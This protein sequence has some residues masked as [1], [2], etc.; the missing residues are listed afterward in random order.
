MLEDIKVIIDKFGGMYSRGMNDT[1]PL[2]HMYPC[3]NATF[4]RNEIRGRDGVTRSYNFN[5]RPRKIFSGVINTDYFFLSLD[6][7]NQLHRDDGA[8]ILDGSP[9]M[10]DFSALNLFNRVYI[11]P[12]RG[13]WADEIYQFLYVYTGTGSARLAGGVKPSSGV[14]AADGAA[15]V[16]S[17][18]THQLAVC[19]VTDTGFIT[20]PNAT[21]T[22][23]V[24]PGLKKIS[25]TNIPLGP[26]ECVGRR[27]LST[28]AGEEEL[29]FVPG[30]GIINDN[31]A[32]TA[33]LDY[34]DTDLVSSA[35]YLL[36]IYE[37]IPAGTQLV[38]YKGR[39][40][41]VGASYLVRISNVQD[42]ETFSTV[43]GF[44]AIPSEDYVQNHPVAGW[45]LRDT[46][47]ISKF[48]GV[49]GVQD[50]GSLFPNEWPVTSIDESIGCYP[51]GIGSYTAQYG[52]RSTADHNIILTQQGIALFN[53]VFLR[54]MM[55]WKV[56]DFWNSVVQGQIN[57]PLGVNLDFHKFTVA[58]DVVLKK[59]YINC[60]T[61]P[62]DQQGIGQD[63]FVLH[64]DYS[65]GWDPINVKWSL[66]TF[67]F[68]PA[69]AVMALHPIDNKYTL[70][71]AS[72][73]DNK[74]W[75]LD[76]DE[77]TDD[78][79][80]ITSILETGLVDR[81]VGVLTFFMGVQL[82]A[83]GA[84]SLAVVLTDDITTFT[85][86]NVVINSTYSRDYLRLTN[87]T[88]E[89]AKLRLT[90]GSVFSINRIEVKCRPMFLQRPQL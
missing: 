57:H 61:A 50:D 64:G 68:R 41:V 76:A 73:L 60:A 38:F 29:F 52:G 51:N 15:G 70:R 42:P 59:I 13:T 3:Q 75:S 6:D 28:K 84:T 72:Y 48:P 19:F 12:N 24:A 30:G 90:G 33:T 62:T 25:L 71:I 26:A 35:D 82:R 27:I 47:Y 1:V 10:S 43:D 45:V 5:F 80:N 32:T 37:R 40:C 89:K 58:H 20:P 36:D 65:E 8:S 77:T 86:V 14:T 69:A 31:T 22:A 2:D 56:E 46:L 4:N 17:K 44:L 39:L 63:W 49:F 87:Y 78:G 79:T 23:Y 7:I 83:K 21:L 11:S 81:E 74:L 9:D 16:V 88:S 53:G 54:P 55:S 34:A 67:P 66:W 18:G 85:G